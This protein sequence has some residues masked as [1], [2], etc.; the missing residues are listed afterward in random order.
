MNANT[1]DAGVDY[2]AL[3]TEQSPLLK[4]SFLMETFIYKLNKLVDNSKVAII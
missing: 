1:F 4:T 3:K 2:F